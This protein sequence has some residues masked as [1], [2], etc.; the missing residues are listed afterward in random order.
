M[1]AQKKFKTTEE[2]KALAA[3]YKRH[4]Q[5]IP[6]STGREIAQVI[7]KNWDTLAPIFIKHEVGQSKSKLQ[8]S[9]IR[10]KDQPNPRGESFYKYTLSHQYRLKEGSFDLLMENLFTYGY[11]D[12][13]L[14]NGFS[15]GY[16]HSSEHQFGVSASSSTDDK[17]IS[18][19]SFRSMEHSI[20]ELE[21]L[22]AVLVK[23]LG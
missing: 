17:K 2:I 12:E 8:Y 5:E 4:T 18:A 19:L 23:L 21:E 13:V 14:S 6:A 10:S 22:G 15:F 20:A 1:S 9:K 3:L 11:Y 7:Y 16:A